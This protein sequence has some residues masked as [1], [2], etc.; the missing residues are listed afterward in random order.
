M[1]NVTEDLIQ[2][3]W[4]IV[5]AMSLEDVSWWGEQRKWHG[6]VA[7]AEKYTSILCYIRDSVSGDMVRVPF[8][9]RQS[10][11]IT[12][13]YSAT[14]GCAVCHHFPESVKKKL[15]YFLKYFKG[16]KLEIWWKKINNI[17]TNDLHL[18]VLLIFR[19][20]LEIKNWTYPVSVISLPTSC[21]HRNI[22]IE[23]EEILL[24]FH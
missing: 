24:T 6:Q 15:K 12:D 22:C 19:S 21:I 20:E 2:H 10:E 8:K 3:C 18:A 4:W 14:D 5:L 11:S 23:K 16:R 7:D 17:K 1:G 13:L 9:G